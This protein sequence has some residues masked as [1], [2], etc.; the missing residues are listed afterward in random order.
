M[1]LAKEK[2]VLCKFETS[3]DM[4]ITMFQLF[5]SGYKMTVSIKKMV[6]ERNY[7]GSKRVRKIKWGPGT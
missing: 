6:Q 4:L 1:F 3:Y 5:I 2:T 7:I